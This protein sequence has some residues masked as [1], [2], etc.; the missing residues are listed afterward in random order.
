MNNC[1]YFE[2]L[3]IL[4]ILDVSFFF[5]EKQTPFPASLRCPP[6]PVHMNAHTVFV[7]IFLSL[8]VFRDVFINQQDLY[9]LWS[10][11]HIKTR[12]YLWWQQFF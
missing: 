2:Y 4:N 1:F 3:K 8:S 10:F 5:L 6:R 9:K 12:R 11:S 7:S